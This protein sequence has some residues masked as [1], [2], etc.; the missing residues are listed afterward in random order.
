MA[1]SPQ[2]QRIL[3]AYAATVGGSSDPR[4]K[5]V[6]DAIQHSPSLEQAL[7]KAVREGTITHIRHDP[8]LINANMGATYNAGTVSLGRTNDPFIL[9]FQLAHEVQHANHSAQKS[10]EYAQIYQAATALAADTRSTT[11]NYTPLISQGLAQN[12]DDEARAQLMGWNAYVEYRRTKNP[13]AT[14]QDILY[15]N[16][17]KDS[18]SSD[19]VIDRAT[20]QEIQNIHSDLHLNADLTAPIT[21]ANIEA[22]GRHY[23]DQSGQFGINHNLNYQNYYA[24][25]YLEMVANAENAYR[26]S[27]RAANGGRA[28]QVRMDMQALG[29]DEARL[30]GNGL[31]IPG[32]SLGYV[33][34][35]NPAAAVTSTLDGTQRAG[36]RFN[37][38]MHAAGATGAYPAG[39][40]APTQPALPEQA[41]QDAN[42][43]FFDRI[44]QAARSGDPAALQPIAQDYMRTE[45]G[46]AWLQKGH[47]QLQEQAAQ[48][49]LEQ[50]AVQQQQ[51]QVQRGPVMRM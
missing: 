18:I 43:R 36:T 42:M 32:R 46:Q 22:M 27:Y 49:A 40:V 6:L 5:N 37:P 23:Y 14:N 34:Q 24:G 25:Y 7:N 38:I 8:G 2:T 48:Q 33:D 28:V 44:V 4:Y 41:G 29:L 31:H 50:Q 3:D 26:P 30:E 51:Q 45:Q 16:P 35:S 20:G 9:I 15:E 39:E 12:R 1:I 47:E 21:P 19:G 11:H 13:S 10:R 17:Y